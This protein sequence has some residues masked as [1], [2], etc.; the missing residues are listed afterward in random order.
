[1]NLSSI[2]SQIFGAA[3]EHLPIE[4]PEVALTVRIMSRIQM[5]LQGAW[6]QA[7][8]MGIGCE[9][10]VRSQTGATSRCSEAMAGTCVA[11]RRPVCIGHAAIVPESGDLVCFGCIG[12]AQ[13]SAKARGPQE[14]SASGAGAREAHS[15]DSEEDFDK[16]RRKYLR[17]LKLQGDP[18]EDEI[19]AAFRREAAKA[20]PDRAPAD[21]RQKAHEKFVALGE[22][23]DWLLQHARKRAA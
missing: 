18:S 4:D 17:R 23:R 14:A 20:H 12:V 7:R 6:R 11:C 2:F 22:A 15:G 8:H 10:I 16:L 19:K 1:M 21:K 3:S 9:Q 13:K 5:H